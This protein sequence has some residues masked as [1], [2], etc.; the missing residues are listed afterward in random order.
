[1]R[2]SV[3]RPGRKYL[4]THREDF[5]QMS[6]VACPYVFFFFLIF[7]KKK[8]FPIS[9]FFSS[10][11]LCQQSS[12]NRNCPSSVCGIS[13][14]SKPI[15]WISFNF[16]FCFPCATT[17]IFYEYFSFS[18]LWDPMGAKISNRCSSYKI[19]AESRFLNFFPNSPH[20]SA[21]EI[22]KIEILTNFIRFR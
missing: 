18:L 21:F 2:V 5:F 1:M 19:A 17:P 13:I 7:G 11:S 4:R 8:Y 20:K 22:L 3:R 12:W 15:A 10:A 14:I 6:I 9:A 16:S